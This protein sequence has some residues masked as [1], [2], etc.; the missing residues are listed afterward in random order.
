MI[1]AIP[2]LPKGASKRPTDERQAESYLTIANGS[3]RLLPALGGLGCA[4]GSASSAVSISL[5]TIWLMPRDD[6][7]ALV[8]VAVKRSALTGQGAGNEP[9]GTRYLTS[10]PTVAPPWAH[11]WPAAR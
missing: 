4:Q 11:R 3:S 2:S 10:W 1:S 8:D 5:R 9:I 6:T 7:T